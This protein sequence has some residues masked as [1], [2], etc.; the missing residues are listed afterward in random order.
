MVCEQQEI[1]YIISIQTHDQHHNIKALHL[2]N[3]YLDQCDEENCT[4]VNNVLA[5]IV[6]HNCSG[7]L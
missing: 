3:F 6:F 7:D 2:I 4:L 5:K 1:L